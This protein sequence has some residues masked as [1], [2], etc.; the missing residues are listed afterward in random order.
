M[1][2]CV[3]A[4]VRACVCICVVD[5]SIRGAETVAWSERQQHRL[6]VCENNWIRIIAGVE[7]VQI[8]RSKKLELMFA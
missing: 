8:E 5:A 2:A 7:R 6:Q 1:C 4:C 3:R